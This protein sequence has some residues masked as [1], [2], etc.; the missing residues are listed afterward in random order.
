MMT[1]FLSQ[2]LMETQRNTPKPLKNC[3]FRPKNQKKTP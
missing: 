1:S 2:K 3:N